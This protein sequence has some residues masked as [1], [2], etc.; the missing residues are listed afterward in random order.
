[1]NDSRQREDAVLSAL[2]PNLE[3]VRAGGKKII[4]YHGWS[5]S[6]IPADFSV[7]YYNA[8]AARLGGDIRDFYRL[9][10]AP[11]MAHCAGGPGPNAFGGADNPAAVY[12]A[13]HDVVAAIERWGE[14]GQA[15]EHIIA[16]KFEGDDPHGKLVRAR[17][18]CVYPAVAK[19]TGK[20]SSDDPT[21]F[22]CADP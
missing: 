4:Q 1:L 6:A 12:D 2:D 8:V 3:R 18:L 19:W 7:S 16:S 11:A 13:E 10:L 17:P 15:P 20:G 9:F 5:D 14:E 21:N 22:V